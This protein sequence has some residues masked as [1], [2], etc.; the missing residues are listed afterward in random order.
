MT[1]NKDNAWSESSFNALLEGRGLTAALEEVEADVRRRPGQVPS[2]L[3]LFDLM[4]LCGQW[5][6]AAKQLQAIASLEPSRADEVGVLSLLIAG[7]QLRAEVFTGKRRPESDDPPPWLE[8]LLAAL[9]AQ[10][11][12]NFDEADLLREKA[13]AGAIETPG[14]LRRGSGTSVFSW[15]AD[16]DSRLGPVLEVFSGNRYLWVP[17]ENIQS[18]HLSAPARPRDVV[19][20]PARL[21]SRNLDSDVFLPV[22]Y[23]GTERAAE[24]LRLGRETVWEEQGRTGVIGLGHKVW[25]TEAGNVPIFEIREVLF[26]STK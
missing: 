1:M 10:A 15:V 25:F 26:E 16:S 11:V 6:R 21:S 12:E 4:C 7:E 8:D 13:F 19:W 9:A 14:S 3:L 18:L 5:E 22:R 17:F 23:P 24:P 20:L 2:R